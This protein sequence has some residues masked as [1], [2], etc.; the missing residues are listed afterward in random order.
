MKWIEASIDVAYY[1]G[2]R[3]RTDDCREVALSNGIA[4][5]DAVV[6][7]FLDSQKVDAFALDSGEPVGM[8]G[9]VGNRVWM[10]GTEKLTSSARNRWQLATEGRKWVDQCIEEVGPLHNYVY[11]KNK[12]SI[13]WLQH[14]GFT[15]TQPEPYGPCAA[16]FCHFWRD[17]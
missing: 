7:S 17:N 8:A 14:L 11:A 3:L 1:V 9:C 15:V 13:R 6:Y 10:L 2:E 12:G 5:T 16:L 4:P